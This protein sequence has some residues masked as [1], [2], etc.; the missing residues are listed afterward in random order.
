MIVGAK[1]LWLP[2]GGIQYD[3]VNDPDAVWTAL[4]AHVD[5]AQILLLPGFPLV[6]PDHQWITELVRE[7]TAQKNAVGFYAEQPYAHSVKATNDRRDFVVDR[8]VQWVSLH[9]GIGERFAKGQACRAYWSQ[10]RTLG[11]HLPYRWLM[12][13]LFWTIESLAWPMDGTSDGDL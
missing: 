11:C 3:R 8:R 4:E 2:F 7:R 1:P 13:E 5:Q 12:P 10:F 9:A 6:H